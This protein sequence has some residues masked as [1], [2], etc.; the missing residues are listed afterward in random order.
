MN[1][2]L[3][4]PAAVDKRT[5]ENPTSTSV[6]AKLQ[7][8]K[9]HVLWLPVCHQPYRASSFQLLGWL[10]E[11]FARETSSPLQ[12][13]R[14]TAFGQSCRWQVRSEGVC[15]TSLRKDRKVNISFD[16]WAC[17]L[18]A[19]SGRS[20]IESSRIAAIEGSQICAVWFI[21]SCTVKKKS[22]PTEPVL[23]EWNSL[24]AA[25]WGDTFARKFNLSIEHLS[26]AVERTW[27]FYCCWLD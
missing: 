5:A 27:S 2:E 10:S 1:D 3:G 18:K 14:S 26:T 6:F 24:S 23:W 12:L 15:T 13:Q 11:L 4:N 21:C 25:S 22:P 8:Q 16:D 17:I 7:C 20:I 9:P 19:F